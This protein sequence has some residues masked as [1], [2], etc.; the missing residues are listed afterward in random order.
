MLT[1]SIIFFTV[2]LLAAVFGFGGIATSAV[3]VAQVL[4]FIFLVAFAVSLIAVYGGRD[5]AP[6]APL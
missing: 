3:G 5:R 2:A 6:K 4:F 1:W